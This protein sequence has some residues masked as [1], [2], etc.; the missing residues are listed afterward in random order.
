MK[1]GI[2]GGTFDPP[3]MGHLILAALTQEQLGLD[4]VLWLLTPFPPHKAGQKISPSSDRLSMVVL[5][6]AGNSSFN[7]SRVDIDREPPHYAVDSVNILRNKNLSDTFFYLMGSDSLIELPTWHEPARFMDACDGL[8]IMKR[9]GQKIN[10]ARLEAEIP[11]LGE[12]LYFVDTPVIEISGSDIRSR[13]KIGLQFR[14][15]VPDKVYHYILNHKLY[16]S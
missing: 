3:H 10:T 5:A 6:I 14:Y 7:L 16:Q 2:F 12:K 1:V 8:V 9:Q 15:L 4:R 13:V 11:G